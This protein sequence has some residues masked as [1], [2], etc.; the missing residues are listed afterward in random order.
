MAV[1]C[2]AAPA[3]VT[4]PPPCDKTPAAPQASSADGKNGACAPGPRH[5]SIW[6]QF[7][8]GAKSR[9]QIL[10]PCPRSILF[11]ARPLPRSRA[12]LRAVPHR[13]ASRLR[14]WNPAPPCRRSACAN[15][16]QY[17]VQSFCSRPLRPGRTAWLRRER[18]LAGACCIL[19]AKFNHAKRKINHKGHK[20]TQRNFSDLYR[21]RSSRK[22]LLSLLSTDQ[23]TSSSCSFV[24]FV[25]KRKEAL[26]FCTGL[27]LR[28]RKETVRSRKP[29]ESGSGSA[30]RPG[31]AHFPAGSGT[32]AQAAPASVA[33]KASRI[34]ETAW[35]TPPGT[36]SGSGPPVPL[37]AQP[38]PPLQARD[39]PAPPHWRATPLT[40]W[41]RSCRRNARSRGY[42]AV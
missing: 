2:K 9:S 32:A 24:S 27:S 34:P 20:G 22:L 23:K 21:E 29:E 4:G 18:F 39:S 36:E 12:A 17:C 5:S 16:G 1:R 38:P 31:D 35:P 19:N 41:M 28:Q 10:R 6:R 33:V 11:P 15:N 3:T 42:A 8:S 7:P 13:S 25:V 30:N 14:R 37:P 40:R 26:R